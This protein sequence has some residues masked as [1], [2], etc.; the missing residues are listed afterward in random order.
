MHRHRFQEIV[1][2]PYWAIALS[3]A[4]FGA[5][6]A[7]H[8]G[9]S[10]S[11]FYV[12]PILLTVREGRPRWTALVMA[13]CL[14]LEAFS[15]LYRRS[16]APAVEQVVVFC[17]LAAAGVYCGR[18]A[19][20][21]SAANKARQRTQALMR[22]VEQAHR[23]GDE[24]A[25]FSAAMKAIARDLNADR[26]RIVALP[27]VSE[28]LGCDPVPQWR[29]NGIREAAA[30]PLFEQASS[31]D[32]RVLAV[33]D[34]RANESPTGSVRDHYDV[35]A[36]IAA[37]ISCGGRLAYLLEAHVCKSARRWNAA[38]SA[39]VAAVAEHIELFLERLVAERE[40]SR[41]MSEALE[42]ERRIN[43]LLQRSLLPSIPAELAGICTSFVYR[44]ASSEY[45]IGG[46]FIDAFPLEGNRVALVIGD[47]AGHGLE[48]AAH[49]S[50]LRS[51]LRAYALVGGSPAT[52][53]NRV[54]HAILGQFQP[55]TFV[56][57]FFAV[58]SPTDGRLDY[59]SAGH[60]PPVI[61]RPV[62]D[63]LVILSPTGAVAGF[64]ADFLCEDRSTF[65]GSGDVIVLLTDG[66]VE[67]RSAITHEMLGVDAFYE[68]VRRVISAEM[69]LQDNMRQLWR[70]VSDRLGTEVLQDDAALLMAALLPIDRK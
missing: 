26:V 58:L 6:E 8:V 11:P 46:D 59:A 57:L 34:L 62:D 52:V 51:L 60:E 66:L 39:Y 38:D 43:A 24:S 17:A 2:S 16:P 63:D 69:D 61:Y 70:A 4:L 25:V 67:A 5:A 47:V 13:L 32:G 33:G 22:L 19:S 28:E 53:I 40:T 23:S 14:V 18:Q 42:R 9:L 41:A 12:F 48:A 55:E 50:L 30:A 29:A 3:L 64:D 68:C 7:F 44:P 20:L 21:I 1:R 15:A 54:N 45:G 49:T 36:A 65:L 10:L 37:R 31:W 56:T 27:P 35:K